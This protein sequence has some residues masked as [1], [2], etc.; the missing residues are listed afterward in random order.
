MMNDDLRR[1]RAYGFW[2]Q[3]HRRDRRLQ[4]ETVS[5]LGCKW[6]RTEGFPNWNGADAGKGKGFN[7]RGRIPRNV[8]RQLPVHRR[9]RELNANWQPK[10][11]LSTRNDDDYFGDT[12]VMRH[13][14]RTRRWAE[15]PPAFAAAA[16]YQGNC[17]RCCPG[18]RSRRST[19][20]TG[21]WADRSN[22]YAIGSPCVI[23]GRRGCCHESSRLM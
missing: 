12:L 14:N 18:G 6:V 20:S 19:A 3:H 7:W 11:R 17:L 15:N 10:P 23:N 5:R 13:T 2:H 9:H 8:R 22:R 16:P 1:N 21:A 4:L